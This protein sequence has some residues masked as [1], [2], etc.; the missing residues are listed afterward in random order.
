[1]KKIFII[2]LF[3]VIALSAVRAEDIRK[4]TVL[5]TNDL[6]GRVSYGGGC[7][8][9]AKI[10]AFFKKIK[11]ERKHVLTLD[12]GDCISGTP[13]SSIFK[14]TP[15]FGIMS[16]MKYDAAAI[17]NHEFDHGWKHIAKFKKALNAPLLCANAFSPDKKLLGDAPHK[18]F[19]RNG[20]KIGVIGV[21]SEYTPYLATKKG[22]GGVIFHKA[23]EI[24][25]AQVKKLRSKCHIIIALTHVG[26]DYDRELA[27]NLKGID[28]IVGGHTHTHLETPEKIN[29]T[30]IVQ[31]HLFGKQVGIVEIDY[32][33]ESKK[34]KTLTGKTVSGKALPKGDQ[35]IKKLVEK[36]EKKVS[37]KVDIPLFKARK[38][39][40]IDETR[41]MFEKVMQEYTTSDFGF[42][43]KK[44]IRGVIFKGPVSIR[45]IWE[46]EPFGNTI[47][48]VK[49]KG[50]NIDGVLLERLS[51]SKIKID[52]KKTYTIATNSYMVEHYKHYI[53]KKLESQ[54][55]TGTLV[56]DAVI[57]HLQ[58]R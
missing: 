21:V 8:G 44:G 7:P 57:A 35:A 23:S 41:E 16:L 32:D 43:N 46:I 36:W 19:E 4:V 14:G 42:Y 51:E 10:A 5:H 48:K 39:L 49:I 20:L 34:I 1:M 31:A 11:S 18:I 37:A 24:L 27:T 56:R 47:F 38:S 17:G 50:V 12:A 58:K 2:G 9:F 29:D 6:H 45:R 15:I 26:I 55:D 33:F 53:G 40:D 52:P 22:N 25:K 13:V 28:L 3:W 54:N 30:W